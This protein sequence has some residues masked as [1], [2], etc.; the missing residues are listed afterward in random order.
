MKFNQLFT[1]LAFVFVIGMLFVPGITFAQTN[2]CTDENACNYDPEATED[3]GS[4]EYTS[5]CPSSGYGA[6]L[7]SQ[8]AVDE[9]VAEYGDC[10][11][12]GCFSSIGRYFADP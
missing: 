8:A 9:F 3:D 6:Y 7:N 2:G 5:C 4:C 10:P 12:I 11:T 1:K